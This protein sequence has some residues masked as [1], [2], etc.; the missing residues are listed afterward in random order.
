[1]RNSLDFKFGGAQRRLNLTKALRLEEEES[2]LCGFLGK[3]FSR[4][5]EEPVQR[6]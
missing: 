3:Q 2:E 1:M 5:P 4:K 6:P